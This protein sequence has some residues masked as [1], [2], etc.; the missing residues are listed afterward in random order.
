MHVHADFSKFEVMP[1][2][3]KTIKSVEQGA[4]TTVFAA[5]DTELEGQ[6]GKY[7]D[8]FE[9][10]PPLPK[11]S[12]NWLLGGAAEWAYDK[13]MAAKLWEMSNDMVKFSESP[14]EARL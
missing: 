9:V 11:G 12:V 5:I 4:A 10:S 8:K 1:D 7:L 14:V 6:G 13:E 2:V 3:S